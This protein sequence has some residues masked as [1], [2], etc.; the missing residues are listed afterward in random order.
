MAEKTNTAG[1]GDSP[2]SAGNANSPSAAT[3][4][5]T[6]PSRP[7]LNRLPP[8]KVLLHND[9]DNEMGYVVE[10]IIELT[11]LTPQAALVRMIEAHRTGVSMLLATHQE[12]AELLQEQFVSKG[13]TV[14]IEPDN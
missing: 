9:D 4:E 6:A 5:R 12:H 1:S 2:K 7:R 14:T 3:R 11:A 10:T 8:W 13:L